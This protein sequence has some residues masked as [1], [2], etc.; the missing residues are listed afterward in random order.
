MTTTIKSGE[1][2]QHVSVRIGQA[3]TVETAENSA[4]LVDRYIGQTLLASLTMMAG[5]TQEFGGYAH[6]QRLH[7]TCLRGSLTVGE[8]DYVASVKKELA[9]AIASVHMSGAGAPVNAVQASAT[10][11]PVG[12]ENG[13]TFTAKEYGA[14]GNSIS[15]AYVDPGANNQALSVSVSYKAIAVSLATGGGGD[16]TSTAAEVKAAVEAKAAAADLVTVAIYAG[17]TGGLDDGSGVVTAMAQ[18]ALTNGAGTGIGVAVKGGLYSDTTNGA[19]YRNS[20]TQAAPA[21][22][23]LA[24]VV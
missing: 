4:A 20:G 5:E 23:Q 15:V 6:D 9:G 12:A 17:D 2:T 1:P 10:I 22:T 7:I 11:N 14:S 19:V 24:D 16:I 18:T 21:W 8:V 13:L 3:L